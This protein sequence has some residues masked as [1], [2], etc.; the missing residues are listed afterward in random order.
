M[1]L[2]EELVKV[3]KGQEQGSSEEGRRGLD[4]EKGKEEVHQWAWYEA[5]LEW[6]HR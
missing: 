3:Q 6:M 5:R 2:Q 1:E 4:R